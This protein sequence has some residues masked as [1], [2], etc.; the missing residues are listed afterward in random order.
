MS[1]SSILVILC[2]F[3]YVFLV[4]SLIHTRFY[5]LHPNKFRAFDFGDDEMFCDKN[6]AEV[7][8]RIGLGL[9]CMCRNKQ[10]FRKIDVQGFYS[11]DVAGYDPGAL[12][13][14]DAIGKARDGFQPKLTIDFLR[15][16]AL[17]PTVDEHAD[18]DFIK[19][20]ATV[21]SYRKAV[22]E[23]FDQAFGYGPFLASIQEPALR[24]ISL[25]MPATS[26]LAC[27]C[28]I[29]SCVKTLP[30]PLSGREVVFAD[31]LG[32]VKNTAKLKDHAKKD[33]YLFKRRD[34]SK[35][36]T[37][38]K[39]VKKMGISLVE[40]ISAKK[41]AQSEGS[42]I[43]DGNYETELSRALD[44]LLSLAVDSFS[45]V[46]RGSHVRG[47]K[48]FLKFRSLVFQKSQN[49][50]LSLTSG[51]PSATKSS[52]D[53]VE[54]PSV[55]P[56]GGL[57]R[58]LSDLQ[59]EMAVAKRK[60]VDIRNFTKE[61]KVIKKIDEPPVR[62]VKQP[63]AMPLTKAGPEPTM[64][65]IQFPQGGSLPS[66]NELKARFACYGP[67][68]HSATQIFRNTFLC[69]VVFRHKAHA[70]AAYKFVVESSS[71]F[72]NTDVKC[73]LKEVGDVGA[74]EPEPP[75]KVP[76]ED[77]HQP[78]VED[79]PPSMVP[80]S[81]GV[82]VKS[83]LK[84]SG[85]EQATGNDS[86]EV[87]GDSLGK[88]MNT[89]KHKDHAKKEET[90]LSRVL[91]DLH[92]LAVD[93]FNTVNRGS[94]IRGK[95]AFLGFR[96]LVFQKSQNFS[97]S[98]ASGE[99]SA[100]K[101]SVD[102]VEMPPVKPQ[103][104]LKRGPSDRQE[105]MTVAKRMKVGDITNLTKEKKVTKKIAE[106]PSRDVKQL[107]ATDLKKPG[108]EFIKKTEPRAPEP[109]MLLIKFPQ[110]GS[111]PSYKELKA[112][113]ASYGPMDHS[114]THIFWNTSS[115]QVVFNHK[116]HAQAAHRFVVG[117][118]SLFGNAGVKCSLKAVRIVGSGPPKPLVKV[119]KENHHQPDMVDR[120]PSM[121][122]ATSGVQMKSI[123]KKSGGEEAAGSGGK[124][125]V[126]FT[127]GRD[128]NRMPSNMA[129][130]FVARLPAILIK[131]FQ[132]A[133]QPSVVASPSPP[134][135]PSMHYGTTLL[136][137]P[138]VL[139]QH[140]MQMTPLR[141]PNADIAQQMLSLLTRCKDVVMDI[142]VVS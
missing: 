71:L 129:A 137:P 74:A 60:K 70:Q 10:N 66:Y 140:S 5:A 79:G 98:L 80:S 51:K 84:I 85:C 43:S 81:S 40:K 11:V 73:S 67:M 48:T 23:D 136:A 1:F 46:N 97:L 109:T 95:K 25:L 119:P 134:P 6:V 126:K 29:I 107:V 72:G 110:G 38:E 96:S 49:F 30:S 24:E 82:Q 37:K 121:V 127:L 34:E 32:E 8:R 135:P 16:L 42:Q 112:R 55:K 58:G 122:P 69:R 19:N 117:S 56:Q 118:S 59:E 106:P 63:V 26:S 124:A 77:H 54:V 36:T 103:G 14:V 76:K 86:K 92:S 44:D 15:Q 99:P 113:F 12:Y 115:C 53:S 130:Q 128:E 89:A 123:M 142:I 105:E 13:S 120:P 57:K 100:S 61:T 116:A 65:M 91:S 75:I 139:P 108:P 27:A 88:V 7:S 131:N 102:S 31:R 50:S 35:E 45:T 111:L 2:C 33:E 4:S 62:D 18:I 132:K 39:E 17:E 114:G 22:Y 104:G 3:I 78:A 83:I 68:D 28:S 138:A 21:M 90:V 47:R 125:R 101:S 52:V 41:A 64:L 87:F 141:V 9:S 20:K 93:P 94:R 133:V